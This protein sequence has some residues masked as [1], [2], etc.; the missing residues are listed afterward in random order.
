MI[1]LRP[2]LLFLTTRVDPAQL[3]APGI[4]FQRAIAENIVMKEGAA[5]EEALSAAID[6]DPKRLASALAQSWS[7][8]DLRFPR[9]YAIGLGKYVL[10]FF[11][12][13]PNCP[14]DVAFKSAYAYRVYSEQLD[15]LALAFRISPR[16]REVVH[17]STGGA[18]QVRTLEA[19]RAV[20]IAKRAE[21]LW[22]IDAALEDDPALLDEAVVGTRQLLQASNYDIEA[23]EEWRVIPRQGRSMRE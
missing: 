9:I 1:S 23:W 3:G 18:L 20:D 5:F 16:K 10:Q 6:S 4:V 22:D 19:K 14:A 17:P 11:N 8:A 2:W 7:W 12:A 15:M 21:R 13:Q